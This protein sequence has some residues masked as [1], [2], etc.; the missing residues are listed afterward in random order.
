MNLFFA[1]ALARDL[2]NAAKG[3]VLAPEL[4]RTGW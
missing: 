1:E 2:A 4:E 3:N